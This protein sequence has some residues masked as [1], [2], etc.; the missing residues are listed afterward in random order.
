MRKQTLNAGRLR[1]RL[2]IE[3]LLTTQ[4]PDTGAIAE[5]WQTVADSVACA[6]EPLS[7]KDLISAQSVKSSV[8]VRIVMRWRAGMSQTVRLIGSDGT[9][10]RP[11]GF[12]PD[13]DSGR[14]YLTAPCK[15][16]I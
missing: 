3:T 15:V 13:P 6:I 7:V 1:H 4:D 9:V 12:M 16:E 10:Y 14:E 8:S 2:R 5:T 11:L